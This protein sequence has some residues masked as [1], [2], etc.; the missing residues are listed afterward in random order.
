M[1]TEAWAV[2]QLA[3]CG[4]GGALIGSMAKTRRLRLPRV[5]VVKQESGEAEW[6]LDPGF[7]ATPLLG[8]F[9][10]VLLASRAEVALWYGLATGY[11]GPA[12]LN[13][14]FD[15][16]LKRLGAD[17]EAAELNGNGAGLANGNG[18]GTGIPAGGAPAAT[19]PG[20]A[21]PPGSVLRS[22]SPAGPGG[23]AAPDSAAPAGNEG[24]PER[25][26]A[27]GHEGRKGGA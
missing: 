21:F 27:S 19:V 18:P 16:L 26:G 22:G 1:V 7:L 3:A 23:Q 15:P 11:V 5:C 8:A 25:G 20:S 9:L 13:L 17:P 14:L 24:P 10:A 4:F 6:I 12:L 2:V